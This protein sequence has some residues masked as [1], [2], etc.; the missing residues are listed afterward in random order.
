MKNG[1][2][3]N[4]LDL[5]NWIINY[6]LKKGA[7]DATVKIVD[8][9]E[10]EIVYQNSFV[11]KLMN[12]R[13][14]RLYLEIYK[15]NRFSSHSTCIRDLDSLEKFIDE[16]VGITS[17]LSEDKC[18]SLPEPRFYKITAPEE[19]ND[20]EI[21]DPF[22]YNFSFDQK[23]YILDKIT[24][25]AL[26]LNGNAVK[27]TASY[28][29][30]LYSSLNLFSNGF[31][32]EK[33]Y[34]FFTAR[35]DVVLKD[36][37]GC[38][39]EDSVFTTTRKFEDLRKGELLGKE[40]VERALAKNQPTKLKSGLYDVIIENRVGV[41][42]ISL[43]CTSLQACTIYRKESCFDGKIG[44][45][46]A[47]EKLSLIDDPFVV[48]GLGSRYFDFEGFPARRHLLIEK[49]T[50]KSYYIDSYYGK[51]LCLAPTSG[52]VSNIVFDYGYLSLVEMINQVKK[53][54]LIT[55]FIGGNFNPVEGNFSFG[56]YG[57]YIENGIIVRPVNEMNLN[58]NILSFWELLCEVGNDPFSDSAIRAPSFWFRDA[59]LS[60]L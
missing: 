42:L 32:G 35:A 37:V 39:S 46:I 48:R 25:G 53:G 26:S 28:S 22:Y 20:L 30:T 55:G 3:N 10:F 47:S 14:R 56:I 59:Q 23:C 16:A 49:G 7:S 18:R 40:A 21:F 52:S 1:T 27:V 57:F 11:D 17:F 5:A 45:K 15:N 44:V 9:D 34:T 8:A 36:Q 19:R 60:G 29:D 13:S 2:Q 24:R 12:S 31:L 54:I 43:F 50:L 4:R 6:A 58:G 51:K 41:K 33:Q 38:L